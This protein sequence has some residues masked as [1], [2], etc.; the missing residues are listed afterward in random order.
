MEN[1]LIY[2]DGELSSCSLDELNNAL[3]EKES[4]CI[5]YLVQKIDE[6]HSHLKKRSPLLYAERE[7]EAECQSSLNLRLSN[8]INQI[9]IA[10]QSDLDTYEKAVLNAL[11]NSKRVMLRTP[12]DDV[13]HNT[14][15]QCGYTA[16]IV[17]DM[18]RTDDIWHNVKSL[19]G[20]NKSRDWGIKGHRISLVTFDSDL[21]VVSYT[22][23]QLRPRLRDP[24][25]LKIMKVC[26]KSQLW[27]ALQSL[28]NFQEWL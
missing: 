12:E 22:D 13:Y 11:G 6:V 18:L 10:K 20:Y 8:S 27:D 24:E 17:Q 28:Y 23:E 3:S 14:L 7:L 4:N 25:K 16:D 9:K 5:S 19:T 2:R 26:L 15:L 1:Y 21:L